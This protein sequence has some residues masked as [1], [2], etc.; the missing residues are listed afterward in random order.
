MCARLLSSFEF[1]SKLK[2]YDTD[3]YVSVIE[4]CNIYDL[5]VIFIGLTEAL[6]FKENISESE[7]QVI[8]NVLAEFGKRDFW[9]FQVALVVYQ[10][11]VQSAL[12]DYMRYDC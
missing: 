12:K 1:L 5:G 8:D 7:E 11:E 9:I 4:V 3:Q 10:E 6:H 2:D